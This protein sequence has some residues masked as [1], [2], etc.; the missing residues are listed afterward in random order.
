MSGNNKL[1]NVLKMISYYRKTMV[2]EIR[3]K[4]GNWIINENYPFLNPKIFFLNFN[5]EIRKSDGCFF[6]LTQIAS[7]LSFSS[8]NVTF[9]AN[10]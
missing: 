4:T 1:S 7:R 9:L 6:A 10:I 3:I 5:N 8:D 2:D